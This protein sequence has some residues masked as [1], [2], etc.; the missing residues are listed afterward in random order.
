[1]SHTVFSSDEYDGEIEFPGWNGSIRKMELKPEVAV[2]TGL[3]DHVRARV[4]GDYELG[5]AIIM[6]SCNPF[7]ARRFGFYLQPQHN[8]D[9]LRG[10]EVWQAS[11]Q[12]PKRG[13]VYFGPELLDI[14]EAKRSTNTVSDALI[15][16][17]QK[18][19]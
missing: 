15:K 2:E 19:A 8:P 4:I 6:R 5:I 1:M 10:L 14:K 17:L 3:G 9:G 13:A 16:S 7:K 11:S 18:A 12:K